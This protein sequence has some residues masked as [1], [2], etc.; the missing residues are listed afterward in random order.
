MRGRYAM[1]H[2]A[3][4]RAHRHSVTRRHVVEVAIQMRAREL[5]LGSSVATV[6]AMNQQETRM[7]GRSCVRSRRGPQAETLRMMLA[8]VDGSASEAIPILASLAVSCL[9]AS[10][11]QGTTPKLLSC[12]QRPARI[13]V[14]IVAGASST[15]KRGAAG[16]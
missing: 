2:G 9:C 4:A 14:V 3:C 12:E 5:P 15:A 13:S 10:A 11:S 6:L 7:T 1:I 16:S 8:L